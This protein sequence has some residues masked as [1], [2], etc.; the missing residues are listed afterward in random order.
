MHEECQN[1]VTDHIFPRS[2][3]ARGAGTWDRRQVRR[4]GGMVGQDWGRGVEV[5][6]VHVENSIER[7]CAG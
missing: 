7:F 5:G 4:P 2:F 1:S 6:G 3:K